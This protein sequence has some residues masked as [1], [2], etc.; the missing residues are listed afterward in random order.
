MRDESVFVKTENVERYVNQ[1]CGVKQL[2]NNLNKGPKC[3]MLE[4]QS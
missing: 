2:D 4:K 3:T 1:K